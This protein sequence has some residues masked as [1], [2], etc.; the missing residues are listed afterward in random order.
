MLTRMIMAFFILFVVSFN[1]VAGEHSYVCKIVNVYE[2][3]NDGSLRSSDLETQYKGSEFLISRVTGE[4][5]GGEVIPA[6]LTRSTKVINKDSG[7][8]H[9]KSFADFA[10]QDQLTGVNGFVPEGRKSFFAIS[11]GG[12]R[13]ITGLCK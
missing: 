9:F 13:F 2:L 4:M 12:N 8:Y 7:E 6:L 11:M 10:C 3:D 1:A 5:I